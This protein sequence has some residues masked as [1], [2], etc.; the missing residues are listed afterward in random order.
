MKL[1]RALCLD[2]DGTIRRNKNGHSAHI[3]SAEEIELM[4]GIEGIIHGFKDDD[5]LICGVSNQAGVA[6]GF[7]TV[8]GCYE[9]M[10]TTLS[11][12]ENDPF[13]IVKWCPFDSAG[14]VEPFNRRS[15]CRKPSIGMLATIE[16]DAM[17]AG[18]IIDWD[19]SL[20]V[21]DRP[22][23]EECAKNA[24]VKFEHIDIFLKRKNDGKEESIKENSEV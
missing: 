19:N 22:E 17:E 2:F 9:E 1:V 10:A 7:K 23:D 11:L 15:L 24:G 4:P 21:G 8:E 12:F 13:H 20:F 18:Y 6:H 16:V 5:Y 14:K 3:N